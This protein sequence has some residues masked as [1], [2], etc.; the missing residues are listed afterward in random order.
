MRSRSQTSGVGSS[1]Q[2]TTNEILKSQ[3]V[4]EDL[5]HHVQTNPMNPL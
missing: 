4:E 1:F 2:E 5:D 3:E